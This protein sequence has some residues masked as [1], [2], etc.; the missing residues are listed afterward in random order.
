MRKINLGKTP[1]QVNVYNKRTDSELDSVLIHNSKSSELKVE[2]HQYSIQEF[3]ECVNI[4]VT[5][6]DIS[7]ADIE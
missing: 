6:Q 2:N 5:V 1:A 7:A 4:G 3:V